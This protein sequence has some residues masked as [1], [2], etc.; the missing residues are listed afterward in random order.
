M[1]VPDP[2]SKAFQDSHYKS[3]FTDSPTKI[4]TGEPGIVI[5]RPS[6]YG[7]VEPT[8]ELQEKWDDFGALQKLWRAS[9][10]PC[11]EENCP[12]CQSNKEDDLD[13]K[14]DGDD[15]EDDED[16]EDGEDDEDEEDGEEDGEGDEDISSSRNSRKKDI[17][18]AAGSHSSTISSSGRRHQD[19]HSSPQATQNFEA[20]GE[21]L[22]DYG[23]FTMSRFHT[24]TGMVTLGQTRRPP[25]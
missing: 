18:E 12:V 8:A 3:A 5:V 23:A 24:A 22:D 16:D 25:L 20:Y 19:V 4:W 7:P 13:D 1:L 10:S 21:R 14:D 15:D 11:S 9:K 6:P 2:Y 17:Q